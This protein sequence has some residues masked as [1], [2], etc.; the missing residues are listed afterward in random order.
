M[1]RLGDTAGEI[2]QAGLADLRAV[3]RKTTLV[4]AD[5][6][7]PK[8]EAD[9]ESQEEGRFS[10][11]SLQADQAAAWPEVVWLFYLIEGGYQQPPQGHGQSPQQRTTAA[12]PM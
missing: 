9:R 5:G 7:V 3:L 6:M 2:E 12:R 8:E 1:K 4:P 10:G 11:Q